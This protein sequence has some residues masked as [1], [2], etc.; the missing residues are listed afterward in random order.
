MHGISVTD[1]AV[2]NTYC[3][4]VIW[5][6]RVPNHVTV[7]MTG[8]S[9]SY[10]IFPAGCMDHS[11]VVYKTLNRSE[12]PMYVVHMDEQKAIYIAS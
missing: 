2:S 4:N 1:W 5:A 7:C 11:S 9:Y 10:S 3:I 8:P 12:Y 6:I